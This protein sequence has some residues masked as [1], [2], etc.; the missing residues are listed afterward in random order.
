MTSDLL[1]GAHA[2]SHDGCGAIA[3]KLDKARLAEDDAFRRLIETSDLDDWHEALGAWLR[4]V[5]IL[6]R[7]K[8]LAGVL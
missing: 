6:K 1:A 4:A 3:S 7:E 5:R 8:F 2:L